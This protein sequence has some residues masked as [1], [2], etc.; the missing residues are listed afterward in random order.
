MSPK[1]S[2]TQHYGTIADVLGDV[3][4]RLADWDEDGVADAPNETNMIYALWDRVADLEREVESLR[5]I[6]RNNKK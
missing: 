1:P 4:P 2:K 5:G 3:S 6:V